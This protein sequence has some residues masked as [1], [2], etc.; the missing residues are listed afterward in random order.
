MSAVSVSLGSTL[1]FFSV[2]VFVSAVQI[3]ITAES[4]QDVTLPC[5]VTN[6]ITAVEWSRA[7]LGQKNV[8]LYQDGRFVPNNQHPSYKNRVA[9]RGMKDGDASLIVKKVTTADSGT[10]KCRV[11][12]AETG[13]WKYVTINLNVSPGE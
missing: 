1:L 9:L 4:G 11:K 7:G 6:N 12:I 2:F 10:Y 5:R 8:F 3:N 13:S